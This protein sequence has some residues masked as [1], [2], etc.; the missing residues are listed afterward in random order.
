[1]AVSWGINGVKGAAV[2]HPGVRGVSVH[3]ETGR[4]AGAR[5]RHRGWHL[6][7]AAAGDLSCLLRG[8]SVPCPGQE[9]KGC[10]GAAARESGGAERD[11]R[12]NQDGTAG[13]DSRRGVLR[14]TRV[15]QSPALAGLGRPGPAA[16][17]GSSSISCVRRG[18]ASALGAMSRDCLAA[19]QGSAE[20][21]AVASPSLQDAHRGLPPCPPH[22]PPGLA[23]WVRLAE[24]PGRIEESA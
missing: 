9:P 3:P 15:E 6:P 17:S 1:M 23:L 11:G 12:Q 21:I 16:W 5:C 4:K 2:I 13:R 7:R 24:P 10:A 8:A 18:W 19:G 14:L 20:P 22:V